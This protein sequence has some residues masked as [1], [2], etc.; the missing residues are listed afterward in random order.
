LEKSL[1]IPQHV[2]KERDNN[3]KKKDP[4]GKVCFFNTAKAPCSVISQQGRKNAHLPTIVPGAGERTGNLKEGRGGGRH[5]KVVGGGIGGLASGKRGTT[6]G[7]VPKFPRV[8]GLKRGETRPP[9]VM[10][11]SVLGAKLKGE[12]GSNLVN[13]RDL[14]RP[15]GI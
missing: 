8:E 14:K 12:G 2:I 6:Q 5:T 10:W 11:K 13:T 15:G 4:L 3:L 1:Q 7:K 9:R